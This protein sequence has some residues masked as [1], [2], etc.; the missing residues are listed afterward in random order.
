MPTFTALS[1]SFL[2]L[3]STLTSVVHSCGFHS[4][5]VGDD[6]PLARLDYRSI[7]EANNAARDTSRR[8]LRPRS[9]AI[10][11]VRVF[12]G[13]SLQPPSTVIL[14]GSRIVRLCRPWKS[15]P[16]SRAATTYDARGMALLPGLIDSHAHPLERA[17]LESLTRSGV[18][19]AV[20]AFCPD[21]V[22]C[23]SLRGHRGLA[24]LVTASFL[25][26]S[27]N[28]THA[29]LAPDPDL[30]IRDIGQVPGFVRRQVAQGAD[31]IKVIGSAPAPGLTQAG[32]AAVVRAAHAAGRRV[33]L[34][35]A[36]S[37][38]YEQAL[39]AGADQ[40]HHAP[41]DK[42]LAGRLVER[43]A[44]KRTRMGGP[45]VAVCPTLTMMR[46]TVDAL[47]PV[48]N[49]SFAAAE[50]TVAALHAAGVPLLAGTD[51]NLQAGTPA[52][53]PFG[54]SL[55]DELE[56]LVAAGLSPVDALNAATALPAKYFGLK[57]RG[58]VREGMLADLVLV[59][60]DPTVDISS[61]R[62]IVKVWARGVE[63][64]I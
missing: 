4:D 45:P 41:L 19:T 28:S 13:A 20:N 40:I 60:G 30:L 26:T 14:D 15:E 58:A 53:V 54:S 44:R 11:N 5:H 37:A 10:T 59:D 46:A 34:H 6:G 63:V 25:A 16:C 31:F 48:A 47:A 2:F 33:V 52:R 3:F 56:N 9:L 51:A 21:P 1:V 7:T 27:P 36:S 17:D 42:A 29:K 32:Q 22:L 50:A 57:D 38:A 49:L 8:C 24:S 39:A 64:D 23:A 61:S 12:D 62:R 35:A 43:L 18:T 55:H